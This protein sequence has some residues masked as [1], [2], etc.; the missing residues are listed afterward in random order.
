MEA[1]STILCGASFLLDGPYF[2]MYLLFT[3][4]RWLCLVGIV[5]LLLYY[6]AL[7]SKIGK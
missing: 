7:K 6:V 4:T 5:G 1:P 3:F 2:M